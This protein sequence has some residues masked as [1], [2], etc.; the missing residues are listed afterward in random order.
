MGER[1]RGEE[2]R[3]RESEREEGESRAR[4]ERERAKRTEAENC[5]AQPEP[6]GATQG[7]GQHPHT[8][9]NQPVLILAQSLPSCVTLG[10]GLNLSE[11]QFL[12][13]EKKH[14][15]FLLRAVLNQGAHLC[16]LMADDCPLTVATQ[17]RLET[18]CW[19]WLVPTLC[20]PTPQRGSV[21]WVC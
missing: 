10:M 8:G 20:F 1:G 3:Q 7:G 21:L 2:R 12:H 17:S 11:P 4:R 9:C 15:G 19:K 18:S 6:P 16:K 14:R 5:F 13:L